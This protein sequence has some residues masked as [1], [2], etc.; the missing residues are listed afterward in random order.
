M[1]PFESKAI[2]E[3]S[4]ELVL[5]CTT[6]GDT[7]AKTLTNVFWRSVA[8]DEAVSAPARATEVDDADEL[9]RVVVKPTSA[10]TSSAPKKAVSVMRRGVMPPLYPTDPLSH[11]GAALKVVEKL[12]RPATR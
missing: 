3:P 8:P 1:A 10:A 12:V 7:R 11:L 2:P 5:I 4:P 9:A 6:D